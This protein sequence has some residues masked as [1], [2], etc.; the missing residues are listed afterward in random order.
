MTELIRAL[1]V[2]SVSG[3]ILAALL[4]ALKPLIKNRLPKAAQ[5]YLWLVVIAALLVPVSRFVALPAGSAAIPSISETVDRLVVSNKDIAD[6]IAPYEAVGEDGLIGIPAE[7][8]PIADE[9]VPEPWYVALWDWC[10]IV[11]MLGAIGMLGY[12]LCAYIAFTDRMKLTNLPTDIS[13]PVPVCRSAKAATPML[14]GLF[15]PVIVLPDREYTEDRLRAVLFHELIHLR[16]RDVLVKWLSVLACAVHWFNPI[17]WLTRREI[18][19]ACELS[20]DEA[21]IANLDPHGRQSYGD[22]LL[23]VAADGKT[24]RAVLSTTMCEEKK[25]LKERLSAIMKNQ[26]HTRAAVITSSAV[27]CATVLAA[28]VLGAGDGN[29]GN[30]FTLHE[31]PQ[32]YVLSG[33]GDSFMRMPSVELFENGNARLSQPLISSLGMFGIGEYK[34]S[35]DELTVRQNGSVVVFTMSDG[36]DTLT[37]KSTNLPFTDVGAVYKYQA[38]ADYLSGYTNVGGEALTIEAL[39]ELAKSANNLTASDFEKYAHVDIDP[40]YHIFDVEGKYTFAVV[41]DADGSTAC[42]LERKADGAHFPLHLNGSTGYVFEAYLGNEKTVRY[43]PRK[44]Y[45]TEDIAHGKT[46]ELTLPEFP[47]VKFTGSVGSVTADTAELFS[48]MPI[49]N[50]YLAD[51]TN[52]GKPELCATVSWGSGIVDTHIAVYDYATGKTY[53]L[54]DRGSYDYSLSLQDGKLMVHQYRYDNDRPRVSSELR[55]VDG[56]LYRFGETPEAP[57]VITPPWPSSPSGQADESV[58]LA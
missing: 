35:G 28:C 39:R 49:W 2:M 47:D 30:S 14:I 57:A 38:R 50:V 23:Y 4:F 21:V 51:L 41:L 19:R 45:S 56:A 46:H 24:P 12:F 15:S 42:N 18:D 52:D 32:K 17:V 20:C 13:C 22:T 3:S 40:D 33:E 43:E 37:V 54:W 55:I 16:R 31:T 29:N 10:C 26:K 36:G 8:Q 5:Y 6:R 44:W 1:V 34:L 53:T 58:G 27:I 9:L 25:D 11:W 48:G 7:F